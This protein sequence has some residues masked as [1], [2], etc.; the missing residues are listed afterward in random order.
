MR[1]RFWR[2]QKV[3]IDVSIE[4][5]VWE[6]VA[7]RELSERRLEES[8]DLLQ[9]MREM[10]RKNHVETLLDKLVQQRIQG[11]GNGT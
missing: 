3:D 2:K 1:V 6:A 4:A 9:E 8:E 10:R 11:G 7:E 5:G